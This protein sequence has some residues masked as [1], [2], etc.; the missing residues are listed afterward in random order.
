[1]RRLTLEPSGRSYGKVYARGE[2]PIFRR[3]VTGDIPSPRTRRH[4]Y[5]R[6]YTLGQY[7]THLVDQVPRPAF[8]P[9]L[10]GGAVAAL[11][12]GTSLTRPS[13]PV[14][15]G[16]LKDDFDDSWR[17]PY[18]YRTHTLKD[19][20]SG[21][22][23]KAT[24]GPHEVPEHGVY[25]SRMPTSQAVTL[26]TV[27]ITG[28]GA[29]YND[30]GAYR[31]SKHRICMNMVYNFNN[32]TVPTL[33]APWYAHEAQEWFTMYKKVHVYGFSIDVEL[34]SWHTS[35]TGDDLFY[36]GVVSDG[37]VDDWDSV[38]GPL[39]NLND[40]SD[41]ASQT[42]AQSNFD[43]QSH[44]TLAP[45]PRHRLHWDIDCEKDFGPDVSRDERLDQTYTGVPA[46]SIPSKFY[47]FNMAVLDTNDNQSVVPT[48]KYELV[49]HCVFYSPVSNVHA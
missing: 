29:G 1:M 26:R 45:T 49:Q 46:T 40:V 41:W 10:A 15:K 44:T 5:D 2:R 48:I 47:T 17:N 7:A 11:S 34:Q 42:Y 39:T 43:T 32:W 31:S 16:R 37:M 36:V 13:L 4:I 35:A 20:I 27:Y 28:P 33:M 12:Y 8:V 22:P 24:H 9:S 23:V 19:P 6:I 18:Y 30:W 21:I 38:P 25:M 14:V 3:L